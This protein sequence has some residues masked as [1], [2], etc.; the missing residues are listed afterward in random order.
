MEGRGDTVCS[1]VYRPSGETRRLCLSGPSYT[2]IP[3]YRVQKIHHYVAF[4]FFPQTSALVTTSDA[5]LKLE[6]QIQFYL[7]SP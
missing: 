3:G 1:P 2:D 7:Y 6:Q 4:A 5:G